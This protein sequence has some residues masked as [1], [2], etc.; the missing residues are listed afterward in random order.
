MSQ[1]DVYRNPDAHSR[2]AFPFVV[3]LQHD[4]V[5]ETE[6]VIVAGL[7][8]SK[9]QESTRLFPRFKIAGRSY[10][11]RTPDLASMPRKVLIAPIAS[12]RDEWHRIGAALDILFTGI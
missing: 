11:M 2:K 12:L 4:V 6:S 9:E 7:V 3:V 8:P 1:F 5:S 10:S